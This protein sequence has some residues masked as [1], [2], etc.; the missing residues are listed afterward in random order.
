MSSVA[1]EGRGGEF[2]REELQELLGAWMGESMRRYGHVN[3]VAGIAA[4]L[5]RMIRLASVG[6]YEVD[7]VRMALEVED[8]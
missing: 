3:L 2:T 1:V 8:E 6:R 4:K 7:D 5:T